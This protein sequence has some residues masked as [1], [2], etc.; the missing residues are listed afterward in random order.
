M[1]TDNNRAHRTS[2]NGRGLFN[3]FDGICRKAENKMMRWH[4]MRHTLGIALLISALCRGSEAVVADTFR[5]QGSTTFNSRLMEP[6]KGEIELATGHKLDVVAN[7]S[8]NGLI[9][10]V[11]G[12][13]ELAMISAPLDAEL[14]VLRVTKPDFPHAMLRSFEIARSR[15]ALA[16]HPSNPV[17]SIS[18]DVLRRV[19]LGDITNW[20]H[21]GGP[22]LRIRVVAVR[23]GGGVTATVQTQVLDGRPFGSPDII[24]LETPKQVIRVVEQETGALGLAQSALLTERRLPEL[25]LDKPI[26][27]ELHVVTFDEPAPTLRSIIDRLRAVARLNLM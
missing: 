27:Q 11:E 25:A 22:D 3:R 16:V 15:V 14:R 1:N 10:L 12:R 6:F 7:K 23:D 9:A 8:I 4:V 19:L 5:V 20:R 26:E 2:A 18:R 13:A 17:R 24:R 21:L